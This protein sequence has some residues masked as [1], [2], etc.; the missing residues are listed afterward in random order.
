MNMD[1]K[2]LLQHYEEEIKEYQADQKNMKKMLGAIGGSSH[3]RK[4]KWISIF[5]IIAMVGTFGMGYL[6]PGF[7][8]YLSIEIGVLLVSVKVLMLMHQQQ[9]MQHFQFW[10]LNSI[11]WKITSLEK[12]QA[13]L[14]QALKEVEGKE[15]KILDILEREP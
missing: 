5:F 7:S 3:A 1:E 8:K 10:I 15:A 14:Q 9:K 4:E 12:K 11:E 13:K 2:E 6:V